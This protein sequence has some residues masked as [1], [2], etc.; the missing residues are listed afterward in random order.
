MYLLDIK[1]NDF[2]E[3]VTVV[4][5]NKKKEVMMCEHIWIDNAWQ[6]PQGG[7]EKGETA[8]EAVM[9]ELVEELGSQ[10][11]KIVEQ[12]PEK[13]KY[14]FPFYLKEK[15][16]SGGN[17]QTFFLIYFYGEDNEIFFTNQEKPEFKNFKWVKYD[18]PPLEVVYFKK[19]SYHQALK[20]FKPIVEKFNPEEFMKNNS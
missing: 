16:E 2:R 3:N 17:N 8:K 9:R 20:H 7:I 6:F 13:L 14:F 12:M 19:I 10:K 15:Y 18:T 5:I 1:M 4:I 11:F